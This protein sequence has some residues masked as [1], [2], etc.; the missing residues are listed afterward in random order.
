MVAKIHLN[1][2]HKK[3][4][5]FETHLGT[6]GWVF[7]IITESYDEKMPHTPDPTLQVGTLSPVYLYTCLLSFNPV[8]SQN[9][10]MAVPCPMVISR[11]SDHLPVCNKFDMRS[12]PCRT[13]GKLLLEIVS[14]VPDGH[15][16]FFCSSAYVGNKPAETFVLETQDA[17]IQPTNSWGRPPSPDSP[18]LARRVRYPSRLATMG[19]LTL[20]NFPSLLRHPT[21]LTRFVSKEIGEYYGQ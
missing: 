21:T 12:D 15:D 2:Q 5:D 13:H 9:F 10:Y 14:I 4:C 17:E 16:C 7:S 1:I 20:K 8:V 11:G 6:C 19:N 3:V 18:L